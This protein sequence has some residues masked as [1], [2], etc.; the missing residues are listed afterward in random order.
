MYK[1]KGKDLREIV[2]T[3]TDNNE[4]QLLGTLRMDVDREMETMTPEKGRKILEDT[5]VLI[6]P[7]GD[8]KFV[9]VFDIF[10]H[11]SGA[12]HKLSPASVTQV[13]NGSRYNPNENFLLIWE[14]YL[15]NKRPMLV[16]TEK[17]F[18][19]VMTF[20]VGETD[21]VVIADMGI[22]VAELNKAQI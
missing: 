12:N 11:N 2:D 14:L 4:G 13:F 17:Y 21:L 18:G 5:G 9:I 6:F 20:K 19:H 15:P 8:I 10:L 16:D 22:N 3:I 7:R 1:L